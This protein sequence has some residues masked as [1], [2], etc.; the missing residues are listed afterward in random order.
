M[1]YPAQILMILVEDNSTCAEGILA[2]RDSISFLTRALTASVDDEK[3]LSR[4]FQA[5]VAGI[6]YRVALHVK[7]EVEQLQLLESVLVN[8]VITLDANVVL[9]AIATPLQ[10]RGEPH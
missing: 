7:S 9:A 1:I 2:S 3:G 4:P 6:I 10:V 5:S 8:H